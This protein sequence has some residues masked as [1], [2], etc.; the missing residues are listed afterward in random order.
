MRKI[1]VLSYDRL[2]VHTRSDSAGGRKRQPAET[3]CL[4]ALI[5]LSSSA[6]SPKRIGINRMA[7]ALSQT[8]TAYSSDSDPEFVRLAAPSTLKMVE[9]LLDQDPRHQGL[10]L[11]A[12]RGFTQYAYGFLQLDAELTN[13]TARA[14]ELTTR[15]RTMY[16]RAK[17]YCWRGL[18]VRRPGLRSMTTRDPEAAVSQLAAS[19]IPAIYWLAAA[20]GGEFG[21]AT[22]QLARLPDLVAIRVLLTRA[23]A[24]QENWERGALHEALIA[25]DGMSP[26]LGGSAA[27]A[28]EHFERAVVLSGGQSAFA[29]VT[30]ASTVSVRNRD[31]AEFD[32]LLR[33][34]LAIDAERHPAT[35]L[36]NLIA[37][38]QARGLLARADQLIPARK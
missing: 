3:W 33:A 5:A 14:D 17:E 20:W 21:L 1:R 31:R 6:C 25:L 16:L 32:R 28:R 23:V 8:A 9:M 2:I 12:C 26:L 29:Y 24:L 35:R 10:L 27:R 22:N 4:I 13:D 30:L 38:K 15:A 37:Q 7:D 34:A 19:D 11:T 18:E 36:M